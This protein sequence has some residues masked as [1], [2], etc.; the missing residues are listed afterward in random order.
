MMKT[1]IYRL[2]LSRSILIHVV[3]H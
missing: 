2:S 3:C 1:R